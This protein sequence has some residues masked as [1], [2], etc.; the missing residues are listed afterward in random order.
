MERIYEEADKIDFY[1]A[2]KS[3][4]ELKF[5]YGVMAFEYI[6][7]NYKEHDYPTIPTNYDGNNWRYLAYMESGKYR[8][9]GIGTQRS[10]NRSEISR[11]RS[12]GTYQHTVYA[13]HDFDF[14]NMMY[15]N[16]INACQDILLTGKTED[17]QSV[18]SAIQK[19]YIKR[20]EN[21]DFF[22]TIPAFSKEQKESFD[23]IV[24]TLLAP[25]M[26][27]YIQLVERFLENYN[28]LFPKHLEEDAERMCCGFF[29]GF[30]DTIAG[31][32]VKKGLMQKPDSSWICD[33][34][35]QWR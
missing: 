22:V 28:K 35:V 7:E 16:Y 4:E 29:M 19:G 21:G 10:G 9:T 20:E 8:R 18:V 24:D 1:R 31:Y 13:M 34:M 17:E 2:G 32:C 30:Y 23:A 14:R 6:S 26:P 25:L 27:E 3:K 12:Q 5:L 11:S 33:V 15:D